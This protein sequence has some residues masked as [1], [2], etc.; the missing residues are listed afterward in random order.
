[1]MLHRK[2]KRVREGG[3]EKGIRKMEG[4]Y[5]NLNRKERRRGRQRKEGK[6]DRQIETGER[7]RSSEGEKN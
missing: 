4:V 6:R 5:E 7:E 3:K 2:R 1:M